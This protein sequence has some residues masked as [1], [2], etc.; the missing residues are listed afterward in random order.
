MKF[1][2]VLAVGACVGLGIEL[3]LA[4]RQ[5]ARRVVFDAPDLSP[6]EGAGPHV[7]EARVVFDDDGFRVLGPVVYDDPGPGSWEVPVAP[8]EAS[9]PD[10]RGETSSVDP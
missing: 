9:M 2:I 3:F 4:R 5:R 1:L 7:S 6:G 10:H 8:H